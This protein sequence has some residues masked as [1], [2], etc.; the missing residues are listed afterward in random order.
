MYFWLHDL[1]L[2]ATK[3][4]HSTVFKLQQ[5]RHVF[6]NIKQ[7]RNAYFDAN[8]ILITI[9][10]NLFPLVFFS[11][12]K[13]IRILIFIHRIFLTQRNMFYLCKDTL[14]GSNS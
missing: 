6:R 13:I 12:V 14:V 11:H 3:F 2:P 1:F 9:I 5:G 8:L 4:S 10:K 7:K